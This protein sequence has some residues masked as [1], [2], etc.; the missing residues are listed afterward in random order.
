MR[1]DEGEGK[2]KTKK[3]KK[4]NPNNWHPWLKMT[5]TKPLSE[6]GSPTFTHI[7]IFCKKILYG[8]IPK[9]S[10]VCAP[11]EFFG[12]CFGGEACNK[13]H[14]LLRDE[15]V[16]QVLFLVESFVKDPKKLNKGQ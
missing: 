3:L 8:I 2:R 13:Q 7:M 10:R 1:A 16:P 9:N 14:V 4:T 12:T 5:L 15:Q 11:N 6:A